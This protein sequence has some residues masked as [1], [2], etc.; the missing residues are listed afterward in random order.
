MTVELLS[1]DAD[2]DNARFWGI[3]KGDAIQTEAAFDEITKPISNETS[4]GRTSLRG[5]IRRIEKM[6]A[7]LPILPDGENPPKLQ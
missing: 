7:R 6:R 5:T 4:I 3:V 1:P 2:D